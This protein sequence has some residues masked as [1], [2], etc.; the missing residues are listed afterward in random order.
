VSAVLEAPDPG[1]T[2]V[3]RLRQ[4]VLDVEERSGRRVGSVAVSREWAM[5]ATAECVQ[6][7]FTDDF[8][9]LVERGEVTCHGVRLVPG[10]PS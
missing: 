3:Y 4:H 7:V 6:Q 8:I 5:Q 9:G 2:A 1:T 10:W